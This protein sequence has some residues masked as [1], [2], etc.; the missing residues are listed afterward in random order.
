MVGTMLLVVFSVATAMILSRWLPTALQQRLRNVGK[1]L[2]EKG[3]KE[4]K[5]LIMLIIA[6][7]AMWFMLKFDGNRE[8]SLDY[9]PRGSY[10]NEGDMDSMFRDW[11]RSHEGDHVLEYR[12]RGGDS[13]DGGRHYRSRGSDGRFIPTRR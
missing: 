1:T 13:S 3:K 8:M 10:Y 2:F 6:A 5:N 12:S 11:G 4:M 9:V 7:L